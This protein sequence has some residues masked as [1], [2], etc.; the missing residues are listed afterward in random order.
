MK[1]PFAVSISGTELIILNYV[2][3]VIGQGQGGGGGGGGTVITSPVGS[4]IAWGGTADEAPE[5]WK[6]CDGSVLAQS[7]FPELYGE[8]GHQYHSWS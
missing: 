8:I 2:G 6:F 5:N 4:I 3:E 7:A 1:K